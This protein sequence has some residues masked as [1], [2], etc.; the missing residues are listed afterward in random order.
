MVK[1]FIN[2]KILMNIIEVRTHHTDNIKKISYFTRRDVK[3]F[4]RSTKTM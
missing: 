4:I 2:I 1:Y 3:T